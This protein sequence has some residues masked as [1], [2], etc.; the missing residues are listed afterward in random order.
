MAIDKASI[1]AIIVTFKPSF[2]D[3][4]ILIKSLEN[5]VC[6]II[7]VNN[8]TRLPMD[9][10]KCGA[11]IKNINLG[12]NKGIA[13]AQN[14][15]IL[16]A[17]RCSDFI[18]TF[19]QDSK[20]GCG[21]IKTL[22]S[23]YSKLSALGYKIACIGPSIINERSGQLYDKYF[24]GSK[25]LTDSS[26]SVNSII[27]SG[28]LYKTDVFASIGLNKA[29]WFID[30]IDIEWCYRARSLGYHI[31]MTKAITMKH[32][33]GLHDKKL[34]F[35]RSINCGSPFRLYYV[36]RNWI[37]SI[38][39]SHFPFKY[40]LKILIFMPIK[41]IIFAFIRPRSERVKYMT[42][43]VIDGLLNKHYLHTRY[44]DE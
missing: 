17:S 16:H 14:I 7:I 39:E 13:Y 2:H 9:D 43:G 36:F 10:I 24:K 31:I 34:L 18:V 26:F 22:L 41:F 11:K 19:D 44:S 40:K 32:N 3:L 38:K 27:S 15:G 4:N 1:S 8:G 30:S 20:V 37:F 28:T 29:H 21:L 35:N 5:Q 33:L 25:K 23:E 6:E 12:E 42:R